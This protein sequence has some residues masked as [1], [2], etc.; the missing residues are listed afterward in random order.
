[1]ALKGGIMTTA[2]MDGPQQKPRQTSPE[3]VIY[4]IERK[5]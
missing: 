4:K 2:R 3:L 1:M 5:D